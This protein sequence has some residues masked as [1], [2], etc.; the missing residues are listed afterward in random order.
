MANWIFLTAIFAGAILLILKK[1]KPQQKRSNASQILE[2]ILF[3]DG[4]IQ[5]RKVIETFN[6]ITN[7]NYSE[8]EIVD[9]FLKEKGLQLLSINHDLSTSVKKYIRQD[10]LIDLNYFERV[11]FHKVFINYP[12]N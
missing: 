2:N 12:L 8:E 9:F 10:T 6:D 7:N 11:K 5:K 3:P 4:N 1:M